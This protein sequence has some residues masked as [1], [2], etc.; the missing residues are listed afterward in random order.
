VTLLAPVDPVLDALCRIAGLRP[1]A[2]V[3]AE[4]RGAAARAGRSVAEQLLVLRVVSRADYVQALGLAG[5]EVVARRVADLPEWDVVPGDTPG[6]QRDPQVVA[7]ASTNDPRRRFFLLEAEGVDR[8]RLVGP[9]QRALSEGYVYAGRI[10]GTQE[11][12][13]VVHTE[14]DARQGKRQSVMSDVELHRDF[15]AMAYDAFRA[16][17]SDIHITYTP[18]RGVVHYRI[19]GELEHVRDLPPD[20]TYSLCSSVYNT[21]LET[22]SSKD[23]FNPAGLQDGVIERR[24]PEGMVRY[25]YSGQ[26]IAPDGFDVV[27]RIIPIGVTTRRKS[28]AELGYSADQCDALER[29]FGRS[30]GLILFAGTTGSG[31]STSMANALW[32][33]AEERPG[34]K[35]R[36]V[37]EPVEYRIPGVAQT[38]V[39]RKHGDRRD[40]LDVLRQLMRS[41]PDVLMI[42]EIRDHDTA[43]L[44]IQAVRSGHLCVSTLHADGAP[45]CYDRLAGMGINRLDLASVGL[46]V[47]LVYQRLVPVL[48]PACKVPARVWEEEHADAGVLVRLRNLLNG[49]VEGIYFRAPAGCRECNGRGV[50]GRTVC[51]EILRPTPHMLRAI[52]EN[53]SNALWRSWRAT[54]NP[55]DPA[56]MTGRTAF[57]HALWKMRQGLVSPVSVESEFRFLDEPVFDG[58][59]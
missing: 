9:T 32:K 12:V 53:D 19:H 17:A 31:K 38:G 56:D 57:E 16:G 39:V 35:I 3:I 41:D 20:Y 37:E 51:A 25:R 47:G 59:A 50:I 43:D 21:L 42:G 1:D 33:L 54:I 26:P 2:P 49:D 28:M 6:L 52:A 27:L 23:N 30:S 4:A 15:D 34:K 55:H 36:S 24:F 40:F 7:I 58:S 8:T 29:M 13:E 14:W 10:R 18:A 45:I 46:V 11:L 48:C 44:A 5:M 22:G